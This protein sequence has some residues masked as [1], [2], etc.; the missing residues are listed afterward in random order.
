M[1][2]ARTARFRPAAVLRGV[3]AA[4]SLA[5][6]AA[7]SADA[8][9]SRS[10][11]TPVEVSARGYD[12]SD[13][14]CLREAIYFEA[15][16]IGKGGGRAV[17]EVILN[18]VES[19]KFPD[20]ICG[21]IS[22]RCQFS[23]RCDGRPETFAEPR[24]LAMAEKV[25]REVLTNPGEELTNGALFFHAASMPPGWFNTLRRT[26]SVGGNIFYKPR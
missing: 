8:N 4:L 14:R 12:Q 19:P 9:P 13:F 10:V 22:D 24:K 11:A 6:L 25:A 18:R 21:V 16:G 17:A 3:T 20:S 2:I 15:G 5:A 1:T 26:A 7:C 23:Y